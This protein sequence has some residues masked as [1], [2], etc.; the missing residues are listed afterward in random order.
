MLGFLTNNAPWYFQSI[1]GVDKLFEANTDVSKEWKTKN[2]KIDIETLEAVDLRMSELAGLYR[3]AIYDLKYRRERVPDNLRWFSMDIYL[4]EFRKLRYTIPPIVSAPLGAL[5]ISTAPISNLIGE[6]N[7]ALGALG[8]NGLEENLTGVMAQFGYLK[9]RCRQCEF[10]FSKS[11][12][13]QGKVNV[14]GTDFKAE[15]NQF[16]IKIGHFEEESKYGTG[17]LLHEDATKAGTNIK[18]PWQTR[19]IGDQIQSA[20]RYADNLTGNQASDR[21][22]NSDIA[23]TARNN[24]VSGAINSGLNQAANFV[25]QNNI[26]QD[27]LGNA[28]PNG[29]PN[30]E[31]VNELGDVYTGNGGNPPVG[32]LGDAY[33]NPPSNPSVNDLG[34]VYPDPDLPPNSVDDLGDV[35][36]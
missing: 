4:A 28:Y 34:D 17:T 10:D 11:I 1:R 12:P 3:N 2:A 19:V 31:S 32:D 22:R 6:A 29:K 15:T 7:N 18:N 13:T 24:A 36:P 16:S 14:G 25:G 27:R 23:Q 30:K 9:F 33:P 8:F 5:G 26:T 21:I 20:L 35:Y